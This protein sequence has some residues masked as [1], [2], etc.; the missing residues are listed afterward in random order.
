MARV[1]LALGSNQDNPLQQL[2]RAIWALHESGDIFVKKISQIYETT[3]IGP[4]QPN[5]LN[6]AM[7]IYTTLSPQALLETLKKLE[8]LQGRVE[9]IPW[10]PRPLDIDILFY[11]ELSVNESNLT[12]PHPRLYERDFVLVPL[13]E[14]YHETLSVNPNV[15]KTILSKIDRTE[16]DA[17]L[18][19]QGA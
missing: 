5:Y 19:Q 16:L 18:M 17:L 6:M 7:L 8:V 14:I 1:Y 10:G 3:P 13:Q 15:T 9:T 4:E 11:D 2:C 12:I